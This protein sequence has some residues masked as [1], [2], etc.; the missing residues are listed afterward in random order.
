MN[1]KRKKGGKKIHD[2]ILIGQQRKKMMD[3]C[4]RV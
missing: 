1:L 4:I 3:I 2:P